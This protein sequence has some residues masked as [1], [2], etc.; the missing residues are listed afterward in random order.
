MR[1]RERSAIPESSVERGPSKFLANRL[2]HPDRKELRLLPPLSGRRRRRPE[3]PKGSAQL[4]H[5][6]LPG[7]R[8]PRP[9]PGARVRAGPLAADGQPAPVPNPP[10][11]RDL[12]QPRDVLLE[13]AAEIPLRHVA[14][15]DLARD[16]CDLL[17]GQV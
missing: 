12:L 17:V 6:L 15:L 13:L 5:R 3:P 1:A 7:H 4:L 11:A 10:V 16:P 8:L 14:A 9:L 2:I